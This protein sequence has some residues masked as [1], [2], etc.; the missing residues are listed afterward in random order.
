MSLS[1][2]TKLGVYEI[3]APLGKGGMGEVFRAR[4]TKLGRDVA[5]KVLTDELTTEERLAR[6]EREARLLASLNHPNIATLYGLE[7]EDGI[8]FLVMELIEGRTLAEMIA[9]GA[10]PVDEALPLFRQI[11]D[12]LES[13]HAKGIVHRDLK[14]ANIMVTPDGRIKVLD[15]GVAKAF[16]TGETTTASSDLMTLTRDGTTPG[17][18]VGTVAYMSPE[19]ARGQT[20]DNRT[21]IWSFGCCLFEALSGKP[22][23]GGKTAS[24]I[25]AR[26]LERDPDWER[27]PKDTPEPIHVLL[28]RCLAKEP[29]SR[30]HA[31]ADAR[32]DLEDIQPGAKTTESDGIKKGPMLFAAIGIIAFAAGAW[33]LGTSSTSLP[34][35]SRTIIP[36]APGESATAD[37]AIS[38]DGNHIVYAA[39]RLY[40]RALDQWEATP[41]PESEGARMPFFSPDSQ[42]IGFLS[43]TRLMKVALSGGAPIL[44]S[45]IAVNARGASWSEDVVVVAPRNSAGLSKVAPDGGDPQIL[46]SLNTERREKS[47]RYPDVL[48]GGKAA[49]FTLGTGDIESW[50]EASIELLSLETGEHRTLL[51]GGTDARYSPTGHIVYARENSLLAVPF[52]LTSLELTGTPV[53]VVD[54]V[55]INANG[56]AAFGLSRDGELLYTPSRGPRGRRRV[57][58]VDRDGRT[59]PFIEEP[60]RFRNVE[61]SPDGRFLAFEVGGANETIWLYELARGNLTRFTFRFDNATPQWSP[62]GE[63]LVFTSDRDGP[64][65]LFQRAVNGND[66]AERLATSDDIQLPGSWTPEGDSLVFAEP[67]PGTGFDIWRLRLSGDRV[68]EAVLQEPYNERRPRLS[69]DGRWLAYVSDES[70]QNEVYIRS[71]PEIGS[72]RQVSIDGGM[73]HQ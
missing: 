28:R 27:L 45:E 32:L 7:N 42:W 16:A 38:P 3:V 24:D 33:I 52:D 15:F 60:R 59:A 43:G 64:F 53:R 12:A 8:V 21:D 30:L 68:P 66:P 39:S 19:Q 37:L 55:A 73:D 58:W 61:F 11:A 51:E 48:P 63:T 26:I 50:D 47:H 20:V 4:D 6:F 67:R 44:V 34:R 22:A 5:I 46:T 72:K 1:P 36:L 14:P 2:G 17:V 23:F 65:N 9:A 62:N 31:I 13:A 57:V 71:F 40:H 69:P 35:P 18:V 56:D 10:L 25:L 49:L 41:I 70:G 54:G 29:R